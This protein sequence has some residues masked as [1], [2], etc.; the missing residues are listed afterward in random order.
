MKVPAL[1]VDC[2]TLDSQEVLSLLISDGSMGFLGFHG[3]PL[4]NQLKQYINVIN[5]IAGTQLLT[6][7]K[8]AYLC[9]VS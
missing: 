9:Q 5:Q 3:K 1:T 2:S 4:S 7:S 6:Y 8:F